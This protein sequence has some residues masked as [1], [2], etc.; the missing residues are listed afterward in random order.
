MYW[1]GL[2]LRIVCDP[3]GSVWWQQRCGGTN[4]SGPGRRGCRNG[5]VSRGAGQR[6]SCRLETL[7]RPPSPS[8]TRA[9]GTAAPGCECTKIARSKSRPQCQRL[10]FESVFPQDHSRATLA[11]AD[12]GH[13]KSSMVFHPQIFTKS[14]DLADVAGGKRAKHLILLAL[15]SVPVFHRPHTQH[16]VFINTAQTSP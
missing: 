3:V 8:C 6:H 11:M 16:L 4:D 2:G 9:R 1:L 15:L 10:P 5:R 7:H 12:D 14:L 13:G